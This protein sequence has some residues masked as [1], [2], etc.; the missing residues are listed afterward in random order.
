MLPREKDF[1]SVE[2]Q[3][4][5]ASA[6]REQADSI[7]RRDELLERMRGVSQQIEE[8]EDELRGVDERLNDLLLQLPNIPDEPG[9]SG[10]SEE[11]Q[12]RRAH[13]GRAARVR[14]RADAPLGAGRRRWASSTSSAASS[15]S[16]TRFYVLQGAG[17]RLQRALITWMLDLHITAARLHRDLPA[18]H[19]QAR[20]CLVG[21]GQLPKFAREP[22][23]RRRGRLLADPHRRGAGDQPAPRRDPG[24]RARC[25]CY[26]VAYTPCFRREKMSAG[27][28]VRGIKRG[29]QF[30][31]VEMFKFVAARDARTTSSKR[32]S[33]NA[34]DVCRG[35]G[36][37]Y[38]I[39][40]LCTGD[41]GFTAANDVRH[42]DVGA[43]LR[44]VAGG[45]LLLQLRATS[46]R[47]GPTSASAREPGAQA[48]SSCHTL[49]GSGLALPRM[50]IAVLEN[51]QQ[52]D[53]TIVVPEVLRPYMG[54]VE[55]MGLRRR[56][57]LRRRGPPHTGRGEPCPYASRQ[58]RAGEPERAPPSRKDDRGG[59]AGRSNACHQRP[60]RAPV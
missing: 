48:R 25:R 7:A 20:D 12:R 26:Y 5:S 29:H 6:A 17:A 54:G 43:R 23:P 49:N 39:V 31:K 52:A 21:T 28:D 37:P 38:R 18:V 60:V 10:A 55:V 40:Q 47:G 34:E 11:R 42:R 16:G 44:R 51:Y 56:G 24:R 45:E 8:L 4:Q 59:W 53:G 46:R 14:L 32:C 9:A 30:D 41:L 2:E 22:V 36:I 50:L 13:G 33:D 1:Q 3:D 27:R 15:S 35:L 57:R 19:G 58:I